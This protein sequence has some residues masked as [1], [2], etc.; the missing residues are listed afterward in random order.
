MTLDPDGG[1]RPGGF[2]VEQGQLGI[3]VDGKA[4]AQDVAEQI[5]RASHEAAKH[6]AR[7]Y[8]N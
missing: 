2:Y 7:K 5:R 1:N 8:A 4:D 3:Y 6:I